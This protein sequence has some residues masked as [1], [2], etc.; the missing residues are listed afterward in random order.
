[1]ST[2]DAMR[3]TAEEARDYW[4]RNYTH[5]QENGSIDWTRP[6]RRP[7]GLAVSEAERRAYDEDRP[8][9]NTETGV[10]VVVSY[11]VD[12]DALWAEYRRSASQAQFVL[13]LGGG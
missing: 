4:H 8:Q 7:L 9:P 6:R 1:M 10:V 5:T 11:H 12:G 13:G 3:W 2:W